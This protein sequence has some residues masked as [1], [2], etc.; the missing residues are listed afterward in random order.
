MKLLLVSD[1]EENALWDNYVPGRLSGYDLILSAGDL[2]PSYL[3]FL[4]TMANKPLLYVHGNHDGSYERFPPEG[5][6]CIE[7]SLVTIG[8]LRIAGLGGSMC[9]SGERHQYTE[10]K[11]TARIRKLN[12]AIRKAGGVDVI[13]THAPIA[14]LGD[15]TDLCHRGFSAFEELLKEWKPALFVH[16]HIHLR[17]S[18][19]NTR[20][21][22]YGGTTVINACGRYAV[23][24]RPADVPESRATLEQHGLI[25][26]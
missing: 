19:R 3:S 13:L 2:K 22:Q 16:G 14:G 7:D 20:V 12:R 15:G 18:N 11:M 1:E 17:Y 24:L 25:L 6:D 10:R 4:V 26:T 8:G 23:S 5:C 21:Q 9:Y